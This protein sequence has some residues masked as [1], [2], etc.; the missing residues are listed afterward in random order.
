MLAASR[1]LLL[2]APLM[3]AAGCA[4]PFPSSAQIASD[5]CVEMCCAATELYGGCLSDWGLK[6][7]AAGHADAES[8]DRS[9][10]TWAWEQTQLH[11]TK[12]VDAL[13]TERAALFEE[14]ICTDY[15]SI[16]WNEDL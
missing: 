9:C 15:T 7:E 4:E 14:G 2:A 5:T 11:G 3:G 8:H 16:D 13:C 12:V 10:Q 6:W 1:S